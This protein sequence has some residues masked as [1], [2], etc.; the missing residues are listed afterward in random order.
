M[1][2]L[3]NKSLL[4]KAENSEAGNLTATC[5]HDQDSG[6]NNLSVRWKYKVL[7]NICNVCIKAEAQRDS[8]R[9][10]DTTSSLLHAQ[11]DELPGKHHHQ[12]YEDTSYPPPRCIQ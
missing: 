9:L 10:S 8:K 3:G 4:H 11:S 1:T 2:K 7:S 6:L 5:N 12:E